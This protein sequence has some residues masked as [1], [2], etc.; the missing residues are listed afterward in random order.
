MSVF[1]V[2][3]FFFVSQNIEKKNAHN[4]KLHVEWAIQK[5]KR[6]KKRNRESIRRRFRCVAKRENFKQSMIDF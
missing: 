2:G 5:R 3:K 6:K 1:R 4:Q